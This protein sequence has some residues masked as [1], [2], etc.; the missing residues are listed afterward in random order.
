M[1]EVLHV[2]IGMVRFIVPPCNEIIERWL[3]FQWLVCWLPWL[4][5]SLSVLLL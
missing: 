4:S 1:L 3:L 5:V 2:Q